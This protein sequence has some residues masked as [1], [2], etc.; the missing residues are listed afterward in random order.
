MNRETILMLNLTFRTPSRSHLQSAIQT[1]GFES[2]S[3]REVLK[4]VKD[5]DVSCSGRT[6]KNIDVHDF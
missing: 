4:N 5:A 3:S 2:L 6:L 1:A